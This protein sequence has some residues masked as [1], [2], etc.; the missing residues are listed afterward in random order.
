MK[1]IITKIHLAIAALIFAASMPFAAAAAAQTDFGQWV[2]GFRQTALAAG[3]SAKV[4][5]RAFQGVDAPDPQVL[6]KAAFQPEFVDPTWNYFDNRINASIIRLG[7]KNAAKWAGWLT[8]IEKRFGVDRNI[9]LAIWSM[10]TGYG[11]IMKRDDVM[12]DAIRSLATLAYA[13][14]KRAR[15]ARTQ[16]LAALKILQ[17]GDIDRA[18]LRGSWAGALGHTQFIPSSYLAYAV[19]IDGDGKRDIWDSVPDALASAANL[20]A[21]NG[22]QPGLRWGYEVILPPGGKKLPAGRLSFRQWRNLGLKSATG[23]RRPPDAEAELKLLDGRNGPAFLVTRNFFALKRYNNSDRYALAV[24]LLADA[25][26]GRPGLKQDW[27]RPFTPTNS[28]EKAEIQQRL[29]DLGLYDGAIDGKI[30]SG[31]RTAIAAFQKQHA[32]EPTGYPSKD[33]LQLLRQNR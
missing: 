31:T 20:L 22:W 19:D 5:D 13:D 24:G 2:A 4:F 25:I 11:E 30:G 18:H 23:G 27:Q 1:N 16:L 12:R 15:Y 8:K 3:I 10:E 17:S 33:I 28:D 21:K 26:G 32:L 14:P 9:L 6:Q 29:K 7:R